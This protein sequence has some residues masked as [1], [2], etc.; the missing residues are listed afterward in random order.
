MH[1]GINSSSGAYNTLCA[2]ALD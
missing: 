1:V 2:R